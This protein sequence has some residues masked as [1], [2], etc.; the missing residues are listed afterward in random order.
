MSIS[1]LDA[2]LVEKAIGFHGLPLQKIWEGE[3]GDAELSCLGI[4]NPDYTVYQSRQK[5]LTFQ[6]RAKRFKLHQFLSKK[7][8]FLY[9][10]AL[11]T[12]TA[13]DRLERKRGGEFQQNEKFVIPPLD[14]FMDTDVNN[15]I[16]HFLETTRPGD[17]VY[18]VVLNRSPQGVIFKVLYSVGNTCCFVNS[19]SIKAYVANNYLIPITDRNGTPRNFTANDLICCEVADAQP[20]ARKL[21]CTM[22]RSILS[23]SPISISYG[24]ISAED[25]PLS[26]NFAAAK[27]GKPYEYYLRKSPSFN[28]PRGVET[29]MQEFGLSATEFY[30]NMSG[31]KGKFP[32]GE[33]S[34]ELRNTQASKW[35]FRSVAEGI[36]HFK[37][38]RHSE[39]FQCLNKALSIDARN[40]E[41]LVARGA[42]YANSGSFKK[43]VDDFEM[44]LKINSSHAN[45]RKYMGETLVALGRSYEEDSRFDDAKK[46]YQDCLNIIPTHEEAQNSLEFLKTKT[47]SKQIVAP[48]ELELPVLHIPKPPSH[49]RSKQAN[50]S[51]KQEPDTSGVSGSKGDGPESRKE[52]KSSK[53]QEKKKRHKK[54]STSSDSSSDS[55]SSESSSGSES[56]SSNSSSTSDSSRS[57]RAKKRNKRSKSVKKPK[58]LSPLSKRMSAGMGNDSRA[59]DGLFLLTNHPATAGHSSAGA[60]EYEQKVRKF[61]D[62]P[63]DE[64][65]YEE[66]VRRFV[67][68]AAK[69]QKERK[70]QE[71]KTK[72]K[73]KKDDKKLKKDSKKKRK[74]ED[75]KRLK[76]KDKDDDVLNN[77]KLKEALKIFENFP[78][79]DELGSK[80]SEYY[81]KKDVSSAAGPSGIAGV[82]SSLLSKNAKKE[83]LKADKTASMK[84]NERPDKD[85]KWRMM[86][87]KDERSAKEQPSSARPTVPKQY[88]FSNESDEESGALGVFQMQQHQQQLQQKANL[89][90]RRRQ[91]SPDKSKSISQMAPVKSGPVVLDKFGNFRLANADDAKPPEPTGPPQRSRSRSRGNRYGGS[92]SRSRS[93]SMKR[94]SRSGSFRRRFSRSR[95][96]SFSRSRSRSYSRSRSRSRSFERRRFHNRGYRGRG[97]NFYDRPFG[98]RFGYHHNNNRGGFM[99][100]RGGFQNFRENYHRGGYRD[101]PFRPRFRGGGG[102][103]GGGHHRFQRSYTRSDS[104]SPDRFETSPNDRQRRDRN[105]DRSRSNSNDKGSSD[106]DSSVPKERD[107][108]KVKEKKET[109]TSAETSVQ[110]A[111]E[112]WS[113]NEKDP[114]PPGADL[115]GDDSDRK[116]T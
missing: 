93:Q 100:R 44:A 81:S 86:F 25:L 83:S 20:D 77:E 10:S 60:D 35:A 11:V 17:V 69:Y 39:A 54:Q 115:S 26:Y 27:D 106:R 84:A 49:D 96:R 59:T 88:A 110:Q 107:S 42:L 55:D 53:K 89:R 50:N 112:R 68:E 61:L 48:N 29:L 3:R 63:R 31:L 82:M 33:Y 22:Q 74:S 52:K 72:K 24:I 16:T 4:I 102:G 108:L 67:A 34:G 12:V 45:A 92:S 101:R 116:G 18:G 47:F 70:A 95:S 51:N 23:R 78:V 36:E 9:D 98:N 85:G 56:S 13:K 97:G 94:R 62:I 64:D 6:D 113:D 46:A 15:K 57:S 66:K 90:I 103:G 1:Q 91:I 38:G 76:K 99:N 104:K 111:D 65:N 41:G 8:E 32:Q 2:S 73:K 87:N 37:E 109:K 114:P 43:A 79:L 71:D 30:T 58:S 28:D 14:T 19:S 40:V 5:T 80:L 21:I 105:Q 75:K 7:A